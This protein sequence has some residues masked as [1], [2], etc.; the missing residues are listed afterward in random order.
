VIRQRNG[1]IL[2]DIRTLF[3]VGVAGGLTD[4]QLLEQFATRCG[5]GAEL[6]FA[7]LVERHGTMV[8]RTCRAILRHD[9]DSED[10]F[11]ATFF[12]LVRRANAL[13]VRDSLGPWLHKVAYRVAVRAKRDAQRRTQTERRVPLSEPRSTA[14]ADEDSACGFLHEEIDRLPGRYR[15]PIVLCDLEGYTYEQAATHLRC[16]VGTVKSRLARGRERLRRRLSRRGLTPAIGLFG[17]GFSAAS[18]RALVPP[19]LV[20]RTTQAAAWFVMNR[21]M[22]GP[23]AASVAFLVEGASRELA[24]SR[25]RNIVFVAIALGVVAIGGRALLRMRGQPHAIVIT[26]ESGADDR[27]G[28]IDRI[29]GNWVRISTDGRPVIKTITMVVKWPTDRP[30]RDAPAGAAEF[31]VEWKTKGEAGGSHNRVLLDPTRGPK[32]LDFFPE[33]NTPPKVCPGIYKLEGETLTIC[34]RATSGERPSDFVAGKPGETLDVYRRAK[35]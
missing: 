5:E 21:G 9:Q 14:E 6:A 33:Q 7:A 12:I 11:Q 29:R 23:A 2:K 4:G 28:D 19:A 34:F 3:D 32:S 26:G 13:W 25:L 15:L 27:R 35:P 8:L 20:D 31:D 16:P 18:A 22:D 17:P 1:A 30:E 10:A 24:M